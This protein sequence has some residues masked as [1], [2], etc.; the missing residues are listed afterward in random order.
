MK[1]LWCTLGTAVSVTLAVIAFVKRFVIGMSDPPLYPYLSTFMILFILNGANV[2]MIRQG[3]WRVAVPCVILCL[4]I[5]VVA[6][7]K[8][9][10]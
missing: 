7:W 5:S 8:V 1:Q 10:F 4:L 6:P 3:E 2:G 9:C